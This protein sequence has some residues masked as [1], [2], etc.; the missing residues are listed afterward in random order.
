MK[1]LGLAGAGFGAAVAVGP[2]YHDLDELVS[3]NSSASTAVHK[4]WWVKEC[5]FEDLTTP[6]D[7]N[8]YDFYDLDA[9][10]FHESSDE[11]KAKLAARDSADEADGI[12]NKVPG[13]TL[14]DF[15]FDL[16][17]SFIGPNAPWD[18]PTGHFKI[19]DYTPWQDTPENNLQMVRA[20]LHTFGAPLV[21]VLPVNEHMKRLFRKGEILWEDIDTAF[22]DDQMVYH[23]PNKA[24]SILVWETLQPAGQTR[25]VLRP[26]SNYPGGFGMGL[27]LGHQ[28]VGHAYSNGAQVGYAAMNFLKGLGYQAVKPT[29][30][31]FY[32]S[33]LPFGVFSGIGEQGR[34]TYLC[35]PEYGLMMRYSYFVVTD[36]PLAPTKP[37]DAGITNFCKT[38]LRCAETCPTGSVPMEKDTSWDTVCVS[39]RPGF[40]GWFM[41]WPTCIDFGAPNKCGV[42]QVMCPFNHPS[43]AIIHPVIRAV[44]GTTGIFNGFFANMD[45]SF[46]YSEAKT[47]QELE[48]WW[49]RDLDKDKIDTIFGTGK[50]KW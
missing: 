26:D 40:K 13:R 34:A 49:T 50:L 11:T 22:R 46:G 30:N 10:P 15:S 25:Y 9:N 27:R 16:A 42:C 47:P 43:E 12:N 4:Q 28:G 37:I 41:N 33:N 6:V 24:E 31:S 45:R 3:S 36:L 38:C 32:Y 21:G 35:S 8:I 5:D 18:G 48:D 20:A 23:F 44:A 7:W 2:V 1:G 39:N 29:D 17:D 19:R 14:R